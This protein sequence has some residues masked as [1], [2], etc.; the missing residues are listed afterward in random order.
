MRSALAAFLAVLVTFPTV[1]VA[2]KHV[3]NGKESATTAPNLVLL[4]VDDLGS[5]DMA[6]NSKDMLRSSPHLLKLSSEGVILTDF[7]ASPECTPSRAMML[8][9][10]LNLKTGLQDSVIHGT[11]PR[12]LPTGET[13]LPQIL[14]ETYGYTTSAIGKWHLGFYQSQYLP[15][16]RGFDK[17]YGILT[18][19]GNHYTHVTT[20]VFS[21]RGSNNTRMKT[22]SGWNL[23]ED[24]HALT[25]EEQPDESVHST[26]LYNQ[27]AADVVLG[28]DF[29]SSP[30]FMYLSYQAVHGPM[31]VDV[32]HVDGTVPNGCNEIA[33]S[34]YDESVFDEDI[35]Y[36]SRAK[37]CGMVSM[38]DK[39][40]SKLRA[41]I[42]SRGAWDNTVVMVMSDNGGVKRHGSSNAPYKGEKGLYFEGGVRVPAFVAGGHVTAALTANGVAAGRAV[43]GLVHI[44]D[45]FST[46]VGLAAA[47]SAS[48]AAKVE[49]DVASPAA[50]DSSA[51]VRKEY[52][53]HGINQWRML[54]ADEPSQR[55]EVLIN[56]NSPIWGGGGALRAGRYKLLVENSVGDS[57]LYNAGRKMMDGVVL[58]VDDLESQLQ[59]RRK[60]VFPEPNFYLFD[61]IANPGEDDEGL[62]EDKVACT[63]LWDDDEFLDVRAMLLKRWDEYSDGMAESNELWQDDGPLADP[64]LFDGSWGPWRDDAGT[65]YA[66]YA[67]ADQHRRR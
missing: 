35:N 43:S 7:Y 52:D 22:V 31:Q 34:N 38:V 59:D 36:A 53:V 25:E 24:D 17:F 49:G 42:E 6:Y 57:V 11:E 3:S 21:I 47:G 48:S 65:P 40:W 51:A 20:E 16:A 27:K 67:V 37:L 9:G 63:N 26:V 15:R 4:V 8:T 44:S 60:E 14:K 33:S 23:W 29:A 32:S 56:M 2:R 39:G 19:G 18:G 55:E 41:A 30:L 5:G 28:H 50:Y 61:L 64:E 12:G 10:R 66:M 58:S 13:L 46:F 54:V 62:C 1:V 45:V